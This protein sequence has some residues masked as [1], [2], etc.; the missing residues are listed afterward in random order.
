[1]KRKIVIFFAVLTLCCT[2]FC[3]C[4]SADTKGQAFVL[5]RADVISSADEAEIEKQAV[6]VAE[7]TGFNIVVLTA[8]DIGTPKTDAHT[9]EFADD[10]YEELCGINTDGILFLINCD[11]KY[12]YISTSGSCINY[13]S[14]ARIDA[15][16]DAIWDDLVGGNYAKAATGFVSRVEYYYN[17]GKANHQQEIAGM[18]VDLHDLGGMMFA[19]IFIGL[20]VGTGIF[21][22]K[23]AQYKMQKPGTRNYILNN[24]LVFDVKTDTF[25]GNVVNRIYTPRSSSS[26]SH[27]SSGGSHRSSTHHSHSGGRHGGGGRHR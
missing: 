3:F 10:T 23:S 17:A 8:D 20:L 19:P 21:A 11:T 15:V 18:E 1:M 26:G 5:D 13:F 14:D 7:K 9:V 25:V 22:A 16:F 24:S 4:A 27:R 2:I 12:D 6:R